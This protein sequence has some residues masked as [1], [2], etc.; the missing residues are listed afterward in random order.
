MIIKNWFKRSLTWSRWLLVVSV[1][2]F[3][4]PCFRLLWVYF[5]MGFRLHSLEIDSASST[6]ERYSFNKTK[7]NQV[8]IDKYLSHGRLARGSVETKPLSL[9]DYYTAMRKDYALENPLENIDPLGDFYIN[10]LNLSNRD[11]TELKSQ[12]EAS[13]RASHW[14]NTIII[15]SNDSDIIGS[16]REFKVLKRFANANGDYEKDINYQSSHVKQIV[17]KLDKK[18][19]DDLEELYIN[20]KHIRLKRTFNLDVNVPYNFPH[21]KFF[22]SPAPAGNLE[23]QLTALTRSKLILSKDVYYS[24]ELIDINLMTEE[25]I[26]IDDLKIYVVRDEYVLPNVGGKHDV[27]FQYRHNTIYTSY[28]LGYA[29]SPGVYRV[30]VKSKA[31]PDWIGLSREFYLL[32]RSPKPLPKGFSIVNLEYTI[33]LNNVSIKNPSGSYEK[34]DAI[35]KWISHMDADALWM[36]AGQTTSWMPGINKHNP[37]VAGG[38]RNLDLLGKICSERGIALGAYVMSYY[39]PGNGKKKVGY[40]PSIGYSSSSDRL[41]DSFHI[42]LE[43]TSRLNDIVELVKKLQANPHV[44]Y[45]GLD[46]IRTGRADGYEMGPRVVQEMN[47]KTPA[48]YDNMSYINQVKW[49]ARQVEVHKNVIIIQKWRWWRA[50]KTATIVNSVIN[51]ASLTKPLWVFTLGWEHGKQHGQDPY[52]FFDAGAH[53][54]AVMLY[55]ANRAQFKNMMKQWPNYMRD[56]RNNVIIGNAVDVR[57]LDGHD[58]NIALEYIRRT[59]E[60]Y[61]KIY[62]NGFA[63]GIFMH[64]ISRALWSSK[65][66]IDISE[67]A[68]VHGHA[69]SVYRHDIGQIPYRAEI[70][71]HDRNNGSIKIIN[72]SDKSITGLSLH[73]IPTAKWKSVHVKA[74]DTID[75]APNEIKIFPF[76]AI[77]ISKYASRKLLLGYKLLHS[78]YRKFFFF[79]YRGKNYTTPYVKISYQ[80]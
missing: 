65:R 57:F 61:R 43:S 80:Q 66:G 33:P 42:S 18:G 46:F 30:L 26:N 44:D 54:D 60:G 21:Y 67:W 72:R 47:I 12:V 9:D 58:G 5:D 51:K 49:F 63:K 40:E 1:I 20:D 52:M 2:I 8:E 56:N 69:T 11:K 23:N 19:S 50:H 4:I 79:T 16:V 62:Q 15:G 24:Y 27:R 45:I 3:I 74:A 10:A 55:E 32:R 48:Y 41:K 29:P 70:K 36:L 71:F 77:P 75:L 17:N 35:V 6:V 22:T 34:Y 28:A 59:K 14:Q 39:T 37:W 31:H 78:D 64:D 73:Y 13:N 25:A 7:T 38:F 53:V 68:I 76:Q